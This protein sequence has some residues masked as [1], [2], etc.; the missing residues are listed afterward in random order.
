MNTKMNTRPGTS[1]SVA[2][3][4]AIA[5]L[6]STIRGPPQVDFPIRE[7]RRSLWSSQEPT[8][9]SEHATR[10]EGP[11]TTRAAPSETSA[12]RLQLC[13]VECRRRTLDLEIACGVQ[14]LL[15]A[16]RRPVFTSLALGRTR[17][18]HAHEHQGASA[19]ATLLAVAGAGTRLGFRARSRCRA[20]SQRRRRDHLGRGRRLGGVGVEVRARATSE[21]T[22]GDLRA[23][24]DERGGQERVAEGRAGVMR[25]QS[26]WTRRERVARLAD[27]CFR[28][29]VG[30]GLV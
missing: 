7:K 16:E 30:V 6:A 3:E 13:L 1:H 14:R 20:G 25:V 17:A 23:G 11:R 18:S 28:V 5:A 15:T 19:P 27:A 8:R 26:G 10:E 4:R 29:A 2:S 24:G 22:G 21:S 12:C 9:N